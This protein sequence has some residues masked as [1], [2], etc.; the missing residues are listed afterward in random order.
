M[1]FRS[2]MADSIMMR[3]NAQL[4]DKTILDA[5]IPLHETLGAAYRKTG[6][7][8]ISAEQAAEAA[9]EGAKTTKGMIAKV[10]RAKW[11][12]DRS[13]DYP[14]GGAVLCCQLMEVLVNGESH[15]GYILPDYEAEYQRMRS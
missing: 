2:I 7:L 5:L 9:K 14:D 3:G 6:D 15:Q 11:I 4:G 1:L 8:K 12:A 10:G 13:R